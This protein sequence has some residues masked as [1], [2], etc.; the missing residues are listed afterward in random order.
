MCGL[1]ET[2]SLLPTKQAATAAGSSVS[3][4]AKESKNNVSFYWSNENSTLFQ[5]IA[6]ASAILTVLGVWIASFATPVFLYYCFLSQQYLTSFIAIAFIT[7]SFVPWEK[8][9]ISNLV[10]K[11][12]GMNPYF[13]KKYTM[14]FIGKSIIEDED[15]DDDG[16]TKPKPKIYGV[17][18]HGAFCLGIIGL[19]VSPPM[20]TKVRFVFAPALYASPFFRLLT[21]LVGRPGPADKAS[22]IKYMK[23]GENIAIPPGGFEEATLSSTKHDRVYIKKRVGF[24]KLALIHG[25]DVVPV[26]VFGENRTYFNVQGNWKMRLKMNSFNLPGIVVWGLSFMPLMPKR[27]KDGLYIV[28]GAPLKLPKIEN[29][30]REEVKLWHDKYI[31]AL[32][33]VFED[34][35]CDAYGDEFGKTAKME[36]W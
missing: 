8:G 22:V 7:I 24:I 3:A 29:P 23:K 35:K 36:L 17:H 34:H 2:T 13:F 28:A 25:Y 16:K 32:V 33:K 14:L 21:R 11:F 26:Y 20:N 4:L 6:G 9:L 1:S 19:F 31:A 5:L 18:P 10:N 15:R 30:T 27:D 12:I